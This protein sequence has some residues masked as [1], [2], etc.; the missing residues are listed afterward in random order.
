MGVDASI[1]NVALP[2]LR[3]PLGFSTAGLARVL[4]AD[5]LT[6]GG[7]PLLGG[8]LGDVLGRRRVYLGGILV[9]TVSSLLAG[10]ATADR[11]LIA[12]RAG[13][14]AGAAVTAAVYSVVFLLTQYHQEVRGLS[15]LRAG[16]APLPMA[17]AQLALVRLV[18]RLV[19]R[20]GP[21][22]LLV[23][24]VAQVTAGVGRLSALTPD[25]AYA[26]SVLG[27]PLLIGAG[28]GLAFPVLSL[29][30]LAGVAP[31]RAGVA[32]GLLQTTQWLGGAL[33]LAVFVTV[34]G[35]AADDAPGATALTEGITAAF[36]AAS[37]AAGTALVL[38]TAAPVRR[39]P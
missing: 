22:T 12:A 13:Q 35:L 3:E 5:T 8:R 28:G 29:T 19:P 36:L 20:S 14:G 27:P 34:L 26:A 24:G 37:I 18:P 10:L 6:F 4:N 7:L 2:M 9:F 31:E 15:P 33:G 32:S 16:L 1:V 23:G 21:A 39:T 25:S 17:L 30:V 11:R 38:A